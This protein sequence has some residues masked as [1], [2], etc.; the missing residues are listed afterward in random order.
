MTLPLASAS[1]ATRPAKFVDGY[2]LYQLAAA[3]QVLSDEFHRK[4][5]ASGVK[6]HVWRVLA[7]VVDQ[8]GMMLTSLSKLVQYEQSRLTKILDQM[9]EGGLVEKQPVK[10]D[11]RKMAIFITDKG[12]EIVTPLLASAK[13]HERR[14]LENLTK[15]EQAMLKRVLNKLNKHSEREEGESAA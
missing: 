5:K 12:R 6:I 11:R 4:V 14:A 9:A 15:S 3:S 13:A 1:G 8:P 2:L 7:C 10:G